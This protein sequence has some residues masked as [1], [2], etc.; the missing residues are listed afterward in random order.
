M[1]FPV[2]SSNGW[3]CPIPY[4]FRVFKHR[5]LWQMQ[6]SP[7]FIQ[8]LGHF[9]TSLYKCSIHR[10]EYL[11]IHFDRIWSWADVHR[12]CNT[13]FEY[14]QHSDLHP[15]VTPDVISDV[16][17]GIS[18]MQSNF[19]KGLLTAVAA[20]QKAKRS[21]LDRNIFNPCKSAMLLGWVTSQCT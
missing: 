2:L 18:C 9:F 6:H 21:I 11:N 20:F 12:N 14:E 15:T 10:P 17:F 3:A 16:T 5:S 4:P 19:T 7:K 1:V 13:F 8:D